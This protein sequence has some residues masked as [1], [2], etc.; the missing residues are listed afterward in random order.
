MPP[1]LNLI[2]QKYNSLTVIKEAPRKTQQLGGNVFVI[3]IAIQ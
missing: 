2:G 1:K 3:A